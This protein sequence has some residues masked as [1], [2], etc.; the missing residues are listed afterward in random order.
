MCARTERTYPACARRNRAPGEWIR[1]PN[2]PGTYMCAMRRGLQGLT[3]MM[4]RQFFRSAFLT[5]PPPLAT[6][7]KNVVPAMMDGQLAA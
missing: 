7:T 6:T 2:V 5:W 1:A 4:F 3:A